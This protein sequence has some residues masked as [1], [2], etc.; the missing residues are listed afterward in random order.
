MRSRTSSESGKGSIKVKNTMTRKIGLRAALVSPIALGLLAAPVTAFA[1]PGDD[2]EAPAEDSSVV[3][4]VPK[5]EDIDL[6]GIGPSTF[7]TTADWSADNKVIEDVSTDEGPIG[8]GGDDD[9]N[10]GPPPKDDGGDDGDDGKD[11]DGNK[12]ADDNCDAMTDEAS[13]NKVIFVDGEGGSN[14][15]VTTCEKG[16]EGYEE[17]ESYDGHVGTKGIAD[18]GAKKEGDGKTPSGTYGLPSGF[19]MKDK[20]AGWS[21]GEY[22]KVGKGDIWVDDSSSDLYNTYVD[23]KTAEAEGVKGESLEQ[24]PAY[25]EALV[26]DYN[27]EQ[28]K[29]AGSAIF[30][31][32]NTGS[33]A[34]AGCVSVPESDLLDIIKWADKDTEIQIV[35]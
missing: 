30:L 7:E 22:T 23:G 13:A 8:S 33:G 14:A 11:D 4:E 5:V 35:K 2:T 19:G 28:K 21:N 18:V 20:P 26:I 16:D 17:V 34:T 9:G 1:A 31:H 24:V 6:S 32:V 27:A 25:N 15:S 12:P 3:A 10:D 29:D